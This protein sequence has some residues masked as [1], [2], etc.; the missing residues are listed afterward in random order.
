MRAFGQQWNLR[1]LCQSEKPTQ[2]ATFHLHGGA[3]IARIDEEKLLRLASPWRWRIA[4]AASAAFV[5]WAAQHTPIPAWN[6]LP[7]S[8]E[9]SLGVPRLTATFTLALP[10]FAALLFLEAKGP[11]QF[12]AG[13]A[14]RAIEHRIAQA[15]ARL[16]RQEL[17]GLAAGVEA[18]W[19][20]IA[21]ER[22]GE[23]RAAAD[24]YLRSDPAQAVLHP[25][26]TESMFAV[27]TEL[28]RQD[29]SELSLS[30]ACCRAVEGDLKAAQTLA[31]TTHAP[32][33]ENKAEELRAEFAS[34]PGLAA[35]RRWQEL[36]HRGARLQDQLT[37]LHA[38]LRLHSAS[39]PPVVL[40]PGTDPYRLL[41]IT[42]DTPTPVLRKLRMHLAQI[43]HPDINQSI[44]NSSKMAEL[45]AAYDAVMKERERSGR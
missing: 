11:I 10:L 20:A 29:L 42:P 7:G 39:V 22:R 36:R 17:D 5:C 15:N 30:L 40:A 23:Y 19:Q 33:Q 31:K 16:Q 8:V 34:L 32:W 35:E 38:E 9:S 26:K 6:L 45:N 44:R 4:A 14:R 12:W 41:G 21:V 18:L 13:R 24:R 27:I 3:I 37:H 2:V 1:Q 28:A 25:Q 43:Y